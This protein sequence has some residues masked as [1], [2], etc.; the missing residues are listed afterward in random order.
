MRVPVSRRFYPSGPMLGECAGSCSGDCP[1]CSC[2]GCVG[3][4]ASCSLSGL[5]TVE[6]WRALVDRHRGGLPT[7][8][9][10]GLMDKVSGG[11]PQKVGSADARGLYQIHPSTAAGLGVN[12]VQLFNPA[13][14][15]QA[16]VALL[17]TRSEQLLDVV[18]TLAQR[19][20]DLTRLTLGAYWYGPA[21]TLAALKAGASTAAAVF[22]RASNGAQ[23]AAFA[24]DVLQRAT[25]YSSNQSPAD[26]PPG[27]V[28][29]STGP[30][31]G[32]L[33]G[34][35][36]LVGGVGYWWITREEM[37]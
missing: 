29:A 19:P 7:P 22:Q 16:A 20:E 5:S 2:V 10:L 15:I 3:E 21:S 32:L 4:C 13:D 12:V 36:L 33:A 24:D 8:V 30:R 34:L 28:G 1:G 18:P 26:L 37:S 9:L 35:A 11:Q 31:W 25:S 23:L 6:Q 14:N 27:S 17:R